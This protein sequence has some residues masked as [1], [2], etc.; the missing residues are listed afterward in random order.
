MIP[1]GCRLDIE[2]ID[3]PSPISASRNG[4][5]AYDALDTSAASGNG[6]Q[7]IAFKLNQRTL[8][9]YESYPSCE[10]RADGWCEL[11]TWLKTQKDALAESD[12]AY[13]CD[14]DYAAPEFGAVTNGVPPTKKS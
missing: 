7:Y 13:S 2:I 3:S 8:P 9:L 5:S 12:Y 14:G 6:T 1:F 10:K 4:S 11:R